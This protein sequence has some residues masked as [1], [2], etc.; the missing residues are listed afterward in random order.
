VTDL[1]VL[2][3]EQAAELLQVDRHTL[4]KMIKAGSVPALRLSARVV[5]IPRRLLLQRLE[6]LAGGD[7]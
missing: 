6:A 7:V 5:R 1:E 2:T 4:T 3:L